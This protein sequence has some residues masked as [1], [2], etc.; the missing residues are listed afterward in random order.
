MECEIV[1][2][3]KLMNAA[4]HSRINPGLRHYRN[5]V[6]TQ[7]QT[8]SWG[9]FRQCSCND[10]SNIKMY[11]CLTF[12]HIH[13][14]T[15]WLKLHV[16]TN[17]LDNPRT[18]CINIFENKREIIPTA[19]IRRQPNIKITHSTNIVTISETMYYNKMFFF[20]VAINGVLF[21]KGSKS[22]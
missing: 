9:L 17:F 8:G 3:D 11:I 6:I 20:Q 7:I 16:F 18:S 14:Y 13:F 5:V 15:L 10:N 2:S 4:Y 12:I 19:L 22:Y 1:S 21:F